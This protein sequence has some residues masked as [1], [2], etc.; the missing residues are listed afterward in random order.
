VRHREECSDAAIHA[1]VKPW[2]AAAYGLAMTAQS[3][4]AL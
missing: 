3:T 2:I 4:M 1:R